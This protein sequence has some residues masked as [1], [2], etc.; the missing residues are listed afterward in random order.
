MSDVLFM[1][2]DTDGFVDIRNRLIVDSSFFSDEIK[3]NDDEKLILTNWY[4][5]KNENNNILE[6]SRNIGEQWKYIW[7]RFVAHIWEDVSLFARILEIQNKC[8]RRI[9]EIKSNYSIDLIHKKE[10]LKDIIAIEQIMLRILINNTI[11]TNNTR[12]PKKNPH[13][14]D[15]SKNVVPIN[16]IIRFEMEQDNE[17]E[18]GKTS[19]WDEH[20]KTWKTLPFHLLTMRIPKKPSNNSSIA[21]AEY[22]CN[23]KSHPFTICYC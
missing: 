1:S 15:S 21:L 22:N 8:E 19:E 12:N 18:F 4:S 7:P 23:L 2:D 14:Y 10:I 9:N 3:L 11:P 13:E 17:I 16:V 5:Q 6:N 20:T